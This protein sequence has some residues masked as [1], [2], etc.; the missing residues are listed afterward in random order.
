MYETGDVN[1]GVWSASPVMGL[2]DQ[3]VSCQVLLKT[4]ERDAEEIM[5]G[6][7]SMIVQKSKL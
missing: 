3:V 7:A 5:L 4:M 1:A 6:N 2:I